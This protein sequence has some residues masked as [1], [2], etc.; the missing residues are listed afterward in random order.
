MTTPTMRAKLRVSNIKP[1]RDKD[2]SVTSEEVTFCG[3]AKNTS[4][5]E[6]GL[7]ENNTYAKFSPQAQLSITIANPALFGK[8]YIG[9]EFY[10]DF[11]LAPPPNT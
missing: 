3:V 9:D 10:V 11:T 8:H 1:N 4:Y 6:D 2:G 7:D 5:G